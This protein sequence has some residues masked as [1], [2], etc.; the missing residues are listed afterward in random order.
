MPF[1]NP[2]PSTPNA[3]DAALPPSSPNVADRALDQLSSTA[4]DLQQQISPL[5]E[6]AGEQASAL[7]QR[8][9][10]AMRARTQHLRDRSVRA[11]DSTLDYIKDE[12]VKAV[13]IAAAAG[14]ALTVLLG[15][16]RKST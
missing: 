11:A 6:R 14:A 10:D 15:L 9:A 3:V 13:L 12:P 16:L 7:A 2:I 1:T 4:Q 8:G 5:F